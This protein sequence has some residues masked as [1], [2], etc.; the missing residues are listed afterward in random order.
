M[1]FMYQKVLSVITQPPDSRPD[2]MIEQLIPWFQKK[3]EL[4]RSVQKDILKDIIRNCNFQHCDTDYVIIHQ[5]EKGDRFYIILHGQVSVYFNNKLGDGEIVLENE[6]SS[7]R[8]K[9]LDRRPYGA[10]VTSLDEGK[11]FGEVAL[12]TEDCVRTASVIVDTK[13]DLLVV[14]RELFNRC[15]RAAKEQEF[16]AKMAFV[17]NCEYF[18]SWQPKCKRQLAMSLIKRTIPFDGLILKQGDPVEGIFY[19]IRGQVKITMQPSLHWRQNNFTNFRGSHWSKPDGKEDGRLLSKEVGA[20]RTK[21]LTV[22]NWLGHRGR[23]VEVCISGTGE[24]V[25]DIEVSFD[26][27]RYLQTAVAAVPC[28]VFLLTTRSYERQLMKRYSKTA[29][30]IKAHCKAKIERRLDR[31]GNMD[32][33]HF[34]RSLHTDLQFGRTDKRQQKLSQSLS[35]VTFG[36][37]SGFIHRDFDSKL[38]KNKMFWNKSRTDDRATKINPWENPSH[39]SNN[40]SPGNTG[41]NRSIFTF[42]CHNKAL[43]DGKVKG[44]VEPFRDWQTSDEALSS[45]EMKLDSWHSE[46]KSKDNKKERVFRLRRFSNDDGTRRPLPG[47]KVMLSPKNAKGKLQFR[48]TLNSA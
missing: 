40:V 29:D 24:A 21:P 30:A 46:M 4:F 22:T 25:G 36:K 13:T 14:S 44:A 41:E 20:N 15:L 3:S 18:C 9:P 39:L 19:I 12:I 38:T 42:S 26:V 16:N 1:A 48:Y 27:P 35:G 33:T 2:A 43:K 45:L 7:V 5:E 32:D 23:S 31:L 11:S 34:L 28:E 47:Q 37:Q 17:N 6:D 10:Y 8:S